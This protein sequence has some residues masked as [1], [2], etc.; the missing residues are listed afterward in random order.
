MR[1]FEE[2]K[3]FAKII[4]SVDGLRLKFDRMIASSF[5]RFHC[6]SSAAGRFGLEKLAV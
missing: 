1:F 3:Y 5:G 2:R 4:E 6:G